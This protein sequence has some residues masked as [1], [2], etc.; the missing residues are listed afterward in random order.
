MSLLTEV[1]ACL[2][3]LWKSG[4]LQSAA[5]HHEAHCHEAYSGKL[6]TEY[7]HVFFAGRLTH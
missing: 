7:V 6:Y 5:Y 1:C 4:K 3:L 2:E